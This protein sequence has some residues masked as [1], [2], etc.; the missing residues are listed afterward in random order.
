[1][2]IKLVDT[3]RP[4]NHVDNEHLG[5]FPV[6]YAEDYQK[7]NFMMVVQLLKRQN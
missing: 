5:T 6:V 4:N 3:A 7:K 1:M 2:A